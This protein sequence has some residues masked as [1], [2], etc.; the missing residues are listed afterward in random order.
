MRYR[1]TGLP[2]KSPVEVDANTSGAIPI[3]AD[4][5]PHVRGNLR[6]AFNRAHWTRD[7][8]CSDVL[9]RDLYARD[10]RPLGTVYATELR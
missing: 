1:V 9:R 3:K 4:I 6:H 10:G 8:L 2:L 5:M 7:K